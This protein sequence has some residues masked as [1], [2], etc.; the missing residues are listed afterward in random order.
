[1]VRTIVPLANRKMKGL[2]NAKIL[3]ADIN[4][5]FISA[6][7][8]LILKFSFYLLM[9]LYIKYFLLPQIPFQYIQKIL[10]VLLWH[11]PES[12]FQ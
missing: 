8:L 9:H 11:R 5:T 2:G 3:W 6:Q 7:P 12:F 1:M 4:F 10:F